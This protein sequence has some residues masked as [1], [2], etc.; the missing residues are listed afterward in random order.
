MGEPNWT[1]WG[2]VAG[3]FLLPAAVIGFQYKK[4]MYGLDL[5]SATISMRDL[6]KGK[7]PSSHN[8]TITGGAVDTK[9]SVT[10][11]LLK[12]GSEESRYYIYPVEFADSEKSG[13]KSD[14]KKGITLLLTSE[15]E[16]AGEGGD[17]KGVLRDLSGDGVSKAVIDKFAEEGLKIDEK[18][19]LVELGASTSSDLWSVLFIAGCAEVAPIS[20]LGFLLATKRKEKSDANREVKIEALR[21]N[22]PPDLQALEGQLR[23]ALAPFAPRDEDSFYVYSFTAVGPFKV[24][25]NVGDQ[26]GDA[27]PQL[28]ALV[29]QIH[30]CYRKHGVKVES[31]HYFCERNDDESPWRFRGTAS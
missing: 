8:V 2:A 28:F 20:V 22:V 1:L 14:K 30:E 21:K 15:S 12:D 17:I 27:P 23:A 16:G 7:K 31:V 13:K 25:L 18:A 26:S 9:H 4:F 10:W 5:G 29:Q 24:T 6:Q 3:L 19:S 11:I